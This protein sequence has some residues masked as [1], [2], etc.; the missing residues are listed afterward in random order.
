ML[1]NGLLLAT[2]TAYATWNPSDKSGVITLSGG[3]LSAS[4]TAT[5]ALVRATLGKSS[6]KW[7]WEV[8]PTS[9]ANLIGIARASASLT[10]WC[11][12]NTNS[13]GYYSADGRIYTNNSPGSTNAAYASGN[14]IGLALNMDAGTLTF[15][16]NGVA[17]PYGVSGLTGTIYPAW[18]DNSADSCTAN[19]GASPFAYTPPTGFT[20]LY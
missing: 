2:K 9:A 12:Q 3:N 20:A 19:F 13:W 10:Q 18:G 6:G 16:K 7:Y 15:Y 14:V 11:G 5:S 17:Q 1:G 4:Q 8:L